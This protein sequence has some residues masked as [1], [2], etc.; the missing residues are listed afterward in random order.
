MKIAVYYSGR[1]QS[2]GKSVSL[3]ETKYGKEDFSGGYRIF[4]ICPYCG[5]EIKNK[6]GPVDGNGNPILSKE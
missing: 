2:C 6:V 4:R 1:C 3:E 5:Y